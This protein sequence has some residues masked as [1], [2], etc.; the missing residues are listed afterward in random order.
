MSN[1][2]IIPRSVLYGLDGK[3]YYS[4]AQELTSDDPLLRKWAAIYAIYK[5][6]FS[7]SDP[8]RYYDF[9]SNAQNYRYA[10]V[11]FSIPTETIE[12]SDGIDDR[13]IQIVNYEEMSSEEEINNFLA[14]N[15]IDPTL[16]L[17]LGAVTIHYNPSLFGGIY[18]TNPFKGKK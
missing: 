14:T 12:T 8:Y 6:D 5:Y 10:T 15:Q 9:I 2:K 7:Q 3:G 1:Q 17:L 13:D 18:W 11:I 16:L 4:I